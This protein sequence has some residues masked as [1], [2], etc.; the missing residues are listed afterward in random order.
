MIIGIYALYDRVALKYVNI[1]QDDTNQAVAKRNLAYGLSTNP[2]LAYMSKD[3]DFT[4]IGKLDNE[5]GIIQ[6]VVPAQ[7]VCHCA[8]LMGAELKEV[9]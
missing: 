1:I 9:N 4:L 6:N 7:V 8:D 2:Q 3:L 5:T